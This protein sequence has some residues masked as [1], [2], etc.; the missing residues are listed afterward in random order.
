M[1][2]RKG[3][4][5]NDFLRRECLAAAHSRSHLVAARIATGCDGTGRITRNWVAGRDG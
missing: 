1:A 4:V 2:P 5:L 3:T